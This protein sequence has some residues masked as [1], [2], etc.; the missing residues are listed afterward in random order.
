MSKNLNKLKRSVIIYV[1]KSRLKSDDAMEI[2]R[3]VEL[4]VDYC[5]K[6][7]FE[8][9][10]ISEEGSSEDWNRKGLQEMLDML[11][12][13]LYDGVLVTDQDRLTRDRTDFGLFV[14]FM[15]ERFLLFFT[16]SK[17]Y[18]FLNDDDIFTSG[19]MSEMDNHVMR[20]TKRKLMRGR[21]Q[22]LEEGIYFGIPPFGYDKTNKKPK[23]LI[24]NPDESEA[25]KLIFDLH[26]NK[27]KNASEIA[28]HLNLIGIK[29]RENKE[30]TNRS[31]Y[32]ILSNVV[33]TG[34]LEYQLKDQDLIA[35]EDA[36][37]A[38]VTHEEFNRAQALRLERRHVPQKASRGK[39]ILSKL[40]K[41]PNCGT[42]LSFCMKYGMR[43]ARK[44][45]DKEGRELY[46]LNCFSSL[47]STKKKNLVEKCPNFGVKASRVEEM[48][49]IELEK[50]VVELDD[51]ISILLEDGD[52]F[53]KEVNNKIATYT[54]RLTQL[55][56]ERKKVQEGWKAGIYETDE[57]T[58]LL[59]EIKDRKVVLSAKK[60]ELEGTDASVEINRK[61][62]MKEKILQVLSQETINV[63]Y[64]NNALREVIEAI[65]FFKNKPDN[66]HYQNDF[67]FA[68]NYK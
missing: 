50:R 59:E 18:N 20:T 34:K 67:H 24:P 63:E 36:H 11:K 31:V 57:A 30:F 60:T 38:I 64:T 49:F 44:N 21:R 46:V 10:I 29:T 22:A 39:Y 19:I 54:Q 65:H 7:N 16:L 56:G 9:K 12:T 28:E 4:C 62:E 2:A 32:Y 52:E 14:R 1:R 61:S 66:T 15:K 25:V 42:T 43:E 55:E 68:V 8:Y 40:I 48:L 5:E 41:C 37:E 23:K 3:Q 33:Y 58:K 26:N 17:T 35:V 6:N 45:L 47:S 51:E 13:D 53:F 27:N